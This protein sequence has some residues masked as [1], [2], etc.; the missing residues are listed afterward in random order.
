MTSRNTVNRQRGAEGAASPRPSGGGGGSH[1]AA[2]TTEIH[3]QPQAGL[4]IRR[5]PCGPRARSFS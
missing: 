1:P 4:A 2:P 5:D 3:E